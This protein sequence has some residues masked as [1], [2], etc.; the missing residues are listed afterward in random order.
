MGCHFKQG[1][2]HDVLEILKSEP[3]SHVLVQNI[4]VNTI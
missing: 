3:Q 1:R 4:A 2:D